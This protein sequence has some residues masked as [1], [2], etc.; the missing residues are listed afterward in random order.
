MK[1]GLRV[2]PMDAAPQVRAPCLLFWSSTRDFHDT[3]SPFLC[4]AAAA[5]LVACGGSDDSVRG[6]LIDPPAVVTHLTAA[7]IDATT[8][9]SGLQALSGKA[10]AM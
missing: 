7:Q 3:V 5:L 2:I 9:A 1:G 4:M 10:G 6:E 8:A